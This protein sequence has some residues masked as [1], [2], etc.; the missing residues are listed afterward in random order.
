MIKLSH[1]LIEQ[2]TFTA[3]NK[4]TGNTSTFDSEEARDAAVKAGTHA[5]VKS[6]GDSKKGGKGGVN[7]FGKDK[8]QSKSKKSEPK[9]TK[10]SSSEPDYDKYNFKADTM[11]DFFKGNLS[12][13][14][15]QKVAKK[16]FDSEIADIADEKDLDGFLNNK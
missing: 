2:E 14:G 6:K 10:S 5:K 9:K 15:L 7:I 8:Q 1:L 3:T 16:N 4:K 13:D 11:T 12:I